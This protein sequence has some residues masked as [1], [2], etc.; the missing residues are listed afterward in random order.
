MEGGRTRG[1]VGHPPRQQT[2]APWLHRA[3]AFVSLPTPDDQMRGVE[4]LAAQ[5]GAL[6]SGLACVDLAQNPGL[7]LGGEPAALSSLWDLGPATIQLLDLAHVALNLSPTS[8]VHSN[9][10]DS[11]G[12]VSSPGPPPS[13]GCCYVNLYPSGCLTV[14]GTEGW[15][16]N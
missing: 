6:L 4:P 3:C 15:A 5:Q 7:I 16:R 10:R 9:S 8:A 13:R 12:R 14:A 1:G 2:A 11:Q